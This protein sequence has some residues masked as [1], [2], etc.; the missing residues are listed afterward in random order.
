MFDHNRVP[1]GTM[2]SVGT[3]FFATNCAE[4]FLKKE[5]NQLKVSE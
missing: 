1:H 2:E 4:L 5:I 3:S